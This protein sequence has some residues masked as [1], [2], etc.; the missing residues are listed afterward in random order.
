MGEK[1][2]KTTVFQFSKATYF[3]KL[4]GI[5]QRS[6]FQFSKATYCMAMAKCIYR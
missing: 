5:Y 6:Q 4:K 3:L 2:V 1:D